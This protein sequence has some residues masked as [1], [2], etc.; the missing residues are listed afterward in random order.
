MAEPK[1][2]FLYEVKDR[3][4]NVVTMTRAVSEKQAIN[5]ARH[6]LIG[7]YYGHQYDFSARVVY[8]KEG[9]AV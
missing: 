1:E 9:R 6:R 4:G 5:N 8:D 3:E 2:R 7:D